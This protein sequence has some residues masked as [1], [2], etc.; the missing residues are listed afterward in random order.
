MENLRVIFNGQEYEIIQSIE[1]KDDCEDNY[2]VAIY[3]VIDGEIDYRANYKECY[4][5]LSDATKRYNYI[6]DNIM[7]FKEWLQ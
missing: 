3:K 7:E 1:L 6:I 5:N 2:I 4:F